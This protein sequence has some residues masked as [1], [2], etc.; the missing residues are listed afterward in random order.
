MANE[1]VYMAYIANNL[2]FIANRAH[3]YNIPLYVYGS[4]SY[5]WNK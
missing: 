1:L 2:P 5:I 3:I 4:L